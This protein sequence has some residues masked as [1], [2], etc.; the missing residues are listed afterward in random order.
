MGTHVVDYNP[1][2]GSSYQ[3]LSSHSRHLRMGCCFSA[4]SLNSCGWA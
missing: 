1:H 3:D 4:N 2:M